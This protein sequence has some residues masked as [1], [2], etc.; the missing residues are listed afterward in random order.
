M[1][2]LPVAVAGLLSGAAVATAWPGPG[3]SRRRVDRAAV[4]R[5][6]RPILV[7]PHVRA[8]GPGRAAGRSPASSLVR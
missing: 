6:R 4:G 2:P 1:T 7:G 8:P 3:A 5:R